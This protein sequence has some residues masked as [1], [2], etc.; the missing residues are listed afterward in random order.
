MIIKGLKGVIEQKKISLGYTDKEMYQY[1]DVS[2]GTYQTLINEEDLKKLDKAGQF[3]VLLGEPFKELLLQQLELGVPE[4]K[5]P[6]EP[7]MI[8]GELV[9]LMK[10]QVEL[11]KQI[12]NK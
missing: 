7:K 4:F 10:Q 6:Q 1:L 3:I 11:L 5:I 8:D 2:K 12:A 9:H